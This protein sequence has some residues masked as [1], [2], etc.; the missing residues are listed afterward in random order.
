[1]PGGY[2]VGR[3]KK[4]WV[5]PHV[6]FDGGTCTPTSATWSA[7]PQTLQSNSSTLAHSALFDS[8]APVPQTT[9]R[10][11]NLP[12]QSLFY[13]RHTPHKVPARLKNEG[14]INKRNDGQIFRGT[15][16][17]R[18]EKDTDPCWPTDAIR[19]LSGNRDVEPP[20]PSRNLG[21]HRRPP[22]R[23]PRE[24]QAVLPRL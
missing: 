10:D 21:S 20:P 22:T 14:E 18:G 23:Q 17:T 13:R 3:D 6:L 24:P 12:S 8:N 11:P 19:R 9:Q 16:E 4:F 5:E 2:V 1:M 7:Q 15:A